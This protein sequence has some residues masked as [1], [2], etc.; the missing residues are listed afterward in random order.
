MMIESY[1]PYLIALA[2]LAGIVVLGGLAE[3]I[4][5]K[6]LKKVALRTKWKGDELVIDSLRGLIFLLGLTG[7]AYAA[8]HQLP[9]AQSFRIIADTLMFVSIVLLAA[10]F[11][12]RLFVGMIKAK[13]SNTVGLLPTSSII[14]NITRIV[15]FVIGILV[16]LQSLGISI[17]PLITALGIGGLA[18]ALALQDTLS[19]FFSGIQVIA[20]RQIRPGDYVKLHSGEEGY[21]SDIT[22]RN[23]TIRMLSNNLVVIPNSK[24]ASSILTNYYLPDKETAVLVEIGVSYDSDLDKVERIT[25][26]AAQQVINHV[27]GGVKGFI[28]FIRYHTFSESSISFTVILRVMEFTDQYLVKHEFVKAIHKKYKENAIEIPF[29]IRTVLFKNPLFN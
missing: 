1:Q 18:V 8:I 20:S 11:F 29:P 26:E 14:A 3:K 9:D 28:P 17:T 12:S 13:A 10:L 16:I 22:W 4:L 15:I 7:G 2:L 23:T 27:E 19:N 5:L 21:V 24:I 25:I 6:R